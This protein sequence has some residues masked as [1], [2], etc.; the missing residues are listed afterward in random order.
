M[1]ARPDLADL[2]SDCPAAGEEEK[3]R[4]FVSGHSAGGEL[5][6]HWMSCHLLSI[7]IRAHHFFS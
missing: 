1:C 6:L 5:M 3:T 7:P 2:K 4:C